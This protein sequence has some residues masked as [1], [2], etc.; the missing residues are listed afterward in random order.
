MKQQQAYKK[1]SFGPAFFFLTRRQ[2][3]AL[4]DYYAFCRLADDIVDEPNQPNPAA[5]L[6]ELSQE[7]QFVYVGAPKTLLGKNLVKDVAD[8]GLERENFTGLLEGMKADLEKKQYQTFEE[9]DWY[10]YRVS[11]LVGK[12]VLSILKLKG[13]QADQLAQTLGSAVQLTNIV[14]DVYEDARMGRVYLPC[15]LQAG[16]VLKRPTQLKEC[17]KQASRRARENYEQAFGLMERFWPVTILPCRIIG[18]IY[19]KNLAKIEKTGFAFTQPVKLTKCEKLQMVGYAI[20]KT[21]F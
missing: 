1:S 10:I 13:N 15:G 17:L 20:I 19:Q 5:Q 6:E 4:A 3:K 16:E 7:V 11:V 14:R 12:T 21:L 18:Y 9:L 8:F 2:R